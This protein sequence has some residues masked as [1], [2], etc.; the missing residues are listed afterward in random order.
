MLRRLWI[1]LRNT[2]IATAVFWLALFIVDNSGLEVPW[3]LAP[4]VVFFVVFFVGVL[5][6]RRA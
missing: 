4:Y 6:T 2:A 3:G 1:A 5:A